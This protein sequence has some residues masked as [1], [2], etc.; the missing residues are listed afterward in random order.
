MAGKPF[1]MVAGVTGLVLV[2]G[3]AAD[4]IA[5]RRIEMELTRPA[6]MEPERYHID[7][8]SARL[9][10]TMDAERYAVSGHDSRGYDGRYPSWRLTVFG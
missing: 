10:Q 6:A 5:H 1:A 4:Q 9:V 7:V 3:T 8:E 2:V